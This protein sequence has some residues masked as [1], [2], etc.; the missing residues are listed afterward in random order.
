[1][2]ASE[3]LVRATQDLPTGVTARVKADTLAH[4]GSD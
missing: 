1:M 4:L 2:K 3:W